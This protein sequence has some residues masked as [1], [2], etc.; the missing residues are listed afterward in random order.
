MKR[1]GLILAL[2]LSLFATGRGP[3]RS[4]LADAEHRIDMAIQRRWSEDPLV[5]LGETRAFYVDGYGVVMTAELNLVTGPTVSPFNPTLSPET[6]ARYRQRKLERLPQLRDLM[7]S[8]VEQA[9]A[10]FPELKDDE[11][12]ALGIQLYRY[13]WEDPAGIPSQIVW[14]AAK[15][16]DAVVKSQDY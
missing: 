9:K 8:T 3:A 7:S 5:L 4:E 10:W 12:I 1:I 15:R 2:G 6:K 11:Q 16:K 13:T 14:Q